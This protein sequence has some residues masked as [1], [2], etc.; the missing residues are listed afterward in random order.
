MPREPKRY[1]RIEIGKRHAV[2][3]RRRLPGNLTENEIGA[4]LQRLACRELTAEEVI[5]SSRRGG[6]DASLLHLRFEFAP[7]AARDLVYLTNI[8]GYVA[9]RWLSEEIPDKPEVTLLP[10]QPA[11]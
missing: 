5:T 4:I 8:P 9:S 6:R 7:K 11:G 1:W 3:F 10:E 2:V